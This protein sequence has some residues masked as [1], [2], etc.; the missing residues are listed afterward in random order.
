M[1]IGFDWHYRTHAGKAANYV[2][3][4]YSAHIRWS[5]WSMRSRNSRMVEDKEKG[6]LIL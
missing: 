2:Q 5:D 4:T 1:S 6:P 3:V